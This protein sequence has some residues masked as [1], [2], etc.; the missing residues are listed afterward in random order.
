M[1]MYKSQTWQYEKSGTEKSTEL[2]GVKIF[3]LPWNSCDE[4]IKVIGPDYRSEVLVSVYE[5]IV[6]GQAKKFAA[7]ELSYGVWGFYLYKY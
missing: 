2:F 5:V 6:D 4:H 3:E 1:K 7:G